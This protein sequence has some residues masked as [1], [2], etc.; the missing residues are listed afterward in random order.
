MAA[1]EVHKSHINEH[2]QELQDAI[3]LG[4][5]KRP[6][7]IALHVSACSIDLLELYL[8][9][10]GKVPLTIMIKHQWF[11]AP[12]EGQKIAPLAERKLEVD[13]PHKQELLSAM[14]VIEELRNKLIYGKPTTTAVETILN[15]FNKI[16]TVT[17]TELET[18]GETI[19]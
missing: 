5:D 9:C 3:A 7:T 15:A 17:K 8:H 16:H 12:K 6:A 2:L 11:K 4:K 18:M 10:L 1:K 14:Y 19:E 13:F